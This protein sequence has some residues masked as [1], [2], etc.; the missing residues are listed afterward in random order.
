MKH[1]LIFFLILSLAVTACGC[2]QREAG[3]AVLLGEEMARVD[4]LP[5]GQIYRS[6]ASEEEAAYFSSH[7]MR[8]MYGEEAEEWCFPLLE[9]Y[10]IYLSSHQAPYEIAVFRCYARS[11]TDRIA[12][13]CLSRV[14]LL[15]IHLARTPFRVHADAATVCVEGRTVIMSLIPTD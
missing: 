3:T 14:E 11:D 13:M 7:L 4:G 12:R 5:S 9:E 1:F 8:V 10:A 6:D 2:R 15:R